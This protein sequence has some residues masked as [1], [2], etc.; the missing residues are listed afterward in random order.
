MEVYIEVKAKQGGKT[1]QI[2]MPL[3]DEDR[4]ILLGATLRLLSR[5]FNCG[6]PILEIDV[7]RA[8]SLADDAKC[9]I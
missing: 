3:A 2:D 6:Q 5:R 4:R 9:A 7:I 8:A 1:E